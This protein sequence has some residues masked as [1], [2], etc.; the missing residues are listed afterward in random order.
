MPVDDE[1]RAALR[2][3]IEATGMTQAAFAAKAEMRTATLSDLLTGRTRRVW[4]DTI[5]K[6]ATAMQMET[7]ELLREIRRRR[8]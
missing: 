5:A 8:Q 2:D 3:M 6:L 4:L 1:F 7:D